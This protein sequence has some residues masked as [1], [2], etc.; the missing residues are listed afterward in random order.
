MDKK[1]MIFGVIVAIVIGLF[2][3]PDSNRIKLTPEVEECQYVKNPIYQVCGYP[4]GCY[5]PRDKR[6]ECILAK[7]DK[8]SSL[9]NEILKLETETQYD[10]ELKVK[11]GS[12]MER[13]VS[14]MELAQY[15]KNYYAIE[16]EACLNS[17]EPHI[18]YA[19]TVLGWQK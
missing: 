11:I 1:I 5:A 19:S 17:S 3:L 9:C 6:V 8:D 16:T 18:G 4:F 2:I 12:S 10:N 7:A 14:Q 13:E 15:K